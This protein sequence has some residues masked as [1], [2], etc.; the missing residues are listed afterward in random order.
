M[1]AQN[2][3]AVARGQRFEQH[4][5]VDRLHDVGGEP[6]FEAALAI[7]LLVHAGGVCEVLRA[8]VSALQAI[9]PSKESA[10]P[11]DQRWLTPDEVAGITGFKK[12]YIL[13]LCRRRLLP[14]VEVHELAHA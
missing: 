10:I 7:V 3:S 5:G 9:P 1:M 11:A 14:S 13:D 8:R 2:R 4:L 12:G 6:C